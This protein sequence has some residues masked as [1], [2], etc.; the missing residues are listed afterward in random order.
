MQTSYDIPLH[1]IKANIPIEEY[2]LYY[3]IGLN[4]ALVLLIMAGLY[5]LLRWFKN[6]KRYS[7]RKADAKLLKNLD[8]TNTKE[9]AYA[10]TLYGATFKDDTPRHTKSYEELF[11][12]L[13]SY[14]YKK[15]VAAFSEE[16]LHFIELY[17][18]MID[19]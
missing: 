1:D 8:L 17:R 16:T 18:G 10:L 7:K 13:E 9:A 19:E 15:E 4:V 6:K 12:A 5:L 11:D 3:L 2:S 14:K